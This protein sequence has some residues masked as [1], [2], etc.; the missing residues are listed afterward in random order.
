MAYDPKAID[1]SFAV[2]LE[3]TNYPQ[4]VGICPA[5]ERDGR[6]CM[7][8]DACAGP[9]ITE[10]RGLSST[11]IEWCF[12]TMLLAIESRLAGTEC[13]WRWNRYPCDY[14]NTIAS[15]AS[16]YGMKYSTFTTAVVPLW[17]ST[18]LS[19]EAYEMTRPD[20]DA[21]RVRWSQIRSSYRSLIKQAARD[22]DIGYG[23]DELWPHYESCHRQCSTRSRPGGTYLYQFRWLRGGAGLV[24]AAF[25]KGGAEGAMD[26]GGRVTS[27]LSWSAAG[28][29]PA[30]STT[31]SSS[32]VITY[33]GHGY[34]ASGPSVQ[35]NLQH[36]LQ[37]VA[38]QALSENGYNSYELGWLADDGVGFFKSGFGGD[39]KNIDV[40]SG[41]I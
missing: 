30:P 41:T 2:V 9:L 13:W 35:K 32:Y 25:P 12:E 22:Y 33:K 36:A 15:I 1:R 6:I 26:N 27:P 5:L 3:G 4:V 18:S 17:G 40:L 7:G 29:S 20:G 24:L 23:Y 34:Y 19:Q 11:R 21:M 38:I 31:L 39:V 8:D 37:W 14:R 10:H 28:S 16:H